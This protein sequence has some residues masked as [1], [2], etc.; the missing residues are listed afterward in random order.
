M[1]LAKFFIDSRE[2][3]TDGEQMGQNGRPTL[4]EAVRVR[5]ER[6]LTGTEDAV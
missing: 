5:H 2:A 6:I 3:Q 1:G 4:S